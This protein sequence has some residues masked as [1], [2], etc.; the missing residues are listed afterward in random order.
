VFGDRRVNIH[1]VALFQKDG[2]M[3][4]L[5][6]TNQT[7]SQYTC[8]VSCHNAC[9]T[10]EDITKCVIAKYEIGIEDH[11]EEKDDV[12]HPS[13]Y[14]RGKYEVNEVLKDWFKA[15]MLD[16]NT[17][18]AIKYLAR[19]NF[20]NNKLKDLKKSAWYIADLIADIEEEEKLKNT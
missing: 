19:C 17:C 9:L 20:K 5:Q 14:N 8:N 15:G 18:C 10:Y 12:N 11:K 13:H 6:C 1:H 4:N 16:W 3:S 7:C 2:K